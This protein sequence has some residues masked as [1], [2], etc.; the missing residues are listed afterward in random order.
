MSG[1]NQ[2]KPALRLLLYMPQAHWRVPYAYQRRHTLALPPYSTVIGLLCNLL[3][4]RNPYGEGAPCRC[5][6]CGQIWRHNLLANGSELPP[7]T[8]ESE[9]PAPQNDINALLYHELVHQLELSIAGTFATKTTEYTWFRNLNASAHKDRFGSETN[10]I[11]DFTA[12]H[13]GGQQPVSIDILN[14]VHLI[15]HIGSLRNCGRFLYLIKHA[16]ENDGKLAG[17]WEKLQNIPERTASSATTSAENCPPACGEC[18]LCQLF[19]EEGRSPN[20]LKDQLKYQQRLYSLH[21]GRAED[22]VVFE[23]VEIVGLQPWEDIYPVSTK[24]FHWVPKAVSDAYGIGGLRYRVPTFYAL[25]D[26]RRL[27]HYKE[28]F[29]SDGNIEPSP[30]ATF[31]P[32]K[33]PLIF[34]D[35]DLSE[36]FTPFPVFLTKMFGQP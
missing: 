32:P 17:A 12:E 13:P 15:I 26:G 22:W 31:S 23:E 16:I 4:I 3:G 2:H 14:D 30:L 36:N 25:K 6:V 7:P 9:G 5:T 21:L 29:L 20:N 8:N 34:C 18:A 27:F 35:P 28:A 19:K 33:S 24:R 11:L 1:N 10:R